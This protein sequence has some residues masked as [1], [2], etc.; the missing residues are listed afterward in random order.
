V[1]AQVER[2]AGGEDDEERAQSGDHGPR[3]AMA[4]WR[5]ERSCRHASTV[6]R[7]GRADN[8]DVSILECMPI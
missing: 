1:V 7:L 6:Q 8:D 4:V 5:W 2:C 3:P